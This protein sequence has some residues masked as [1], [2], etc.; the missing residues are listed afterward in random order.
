MTAEERQE[1]ART[2]GLVGG[3][4][5]ADSLTAK[6]RKEIASKAAKARWKGRSQ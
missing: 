2:A 6:R 1:S 4:A 3:R 5:R